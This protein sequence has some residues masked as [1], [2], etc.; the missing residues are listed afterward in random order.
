MPQATWLIETGFEACDDYTELSDDQII[1][2]IQNAGI[3][4][5]GGAGFPTHVKLSPNKPESIEF[6]IANCAECEPYLTSDYR[7]M[8][9]E[10]EKLITGMKIILQ[11]FPKV[12]V[13]CV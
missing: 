11:L 13:I 7:S 4:G 3:V 10:P 8:V 5:M 12:S 1:S 2:K 9:E 6:I